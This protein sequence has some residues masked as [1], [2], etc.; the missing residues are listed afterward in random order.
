ML[1]LSRSF[2]PRNQLAWRTILLTDKIDGVKDFS[3]S[4]SFISRFGISTTTSYSRNDGINSDRTS[5]A[6]S[7]FKGKAALFM[8][9][10]PPTF[11]K[12]DSG[13]SVV[14]RKGSVMLKFMPAIGPRKYDSERKQL[15]ALSANEV[16]CLVSL[17]SDESCEFFHDPSLKSS[18]EGQV[19][20]T[21]AI[22]PLT[23][24]SGY[25][26]H[27]SVMNSQLKTNERV[28]IPVTKAEFAVI[29]SAFSFALPH[30]LGWDRI[31]SPQ[32]EGSSSPAHLNKQGALKATA[33][34]DYEW[35]R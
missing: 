1:R 9:P 26:F 13:I 32:F 11:S 19:K 10:I 23:D 31:I 16:G 8:Y 30:L 17:G 15:F 18:L 3:R 33:D 34:A 25:M 20:K 22:T 21:L 28:T 35:D 5:A 12:I 27:L 29:R 7:I 4:N 6:Y 2:F 24:G 14:D